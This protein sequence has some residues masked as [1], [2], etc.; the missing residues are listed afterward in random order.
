MNETFSFPGLSLE[1]VLTL[2]DETVRMSHRPRASGHGVGVP[3]ET[4]GSGRPGAAGQAAAGREYPDPQ[5]AVQTVPA[6]RPAT[7][8]EAIVQ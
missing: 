7:G 1:L 8:S 3:A 6:A 5:A 4:H 2:K